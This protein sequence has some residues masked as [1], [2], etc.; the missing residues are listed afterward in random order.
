[1]P[2]VFELYDYWNNWPPEHTLLKWFVGYRAPKKPPKEALFNDKTTGSVVN[3]FDRLPVHLQ[4][5]VIKSDGCNTIAEWK[6]K[7]K[8]KV[9]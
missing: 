2:D 6:D 4:D 5:A 3:D 8:N 9:N 7:N 1:M